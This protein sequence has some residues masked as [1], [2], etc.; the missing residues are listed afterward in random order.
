[1]SAHTLDKLIYM[2]NHIA[3]N[4]THDAD[5]VSMIADHIKAFWSPRMLQQ[6]FAVLDGPEGAQIDPVSHAALARLAAQAANAA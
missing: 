3:R 1:M 2:A 4:V 6:I 5:P